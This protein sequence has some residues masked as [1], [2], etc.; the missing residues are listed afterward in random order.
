MKR[1]YFAGHQYVEFS[2]EKKINSIE[3]IIFTEKKV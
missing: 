1:K 3:Q 2:E